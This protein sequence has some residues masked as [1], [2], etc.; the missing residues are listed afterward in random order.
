M[1]RR[2]SRNAIDDLKAT[3]FRRLTERFLRVNVTPGKVDW[4][5][6]QAWA[7][8]LQNYTSQPETRDGLREPTPAGLGR[9]PA[10]A[11]TLVTRR[12]TGQNAPDGL[13]RLGR[14]LAVRRRLTRRRQG[15]L[16]CDIVSAADRAGYQRRGWGK[17]IRDR[18][19]E[20][21]EEQRPVD[22]C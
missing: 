22:A 9:E 1:W 19:D 2:T 10:L 20:G 6:D 13:V 12:K 17:R 15:F 14:M 5:D 3:P 16:A 7:V 8:V 11:C 21:T 4:F 18:K